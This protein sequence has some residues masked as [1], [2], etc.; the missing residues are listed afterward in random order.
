ME[1]SNQEKQL[2]SL[3]E[4][5]RAEKSKFNHRLL[6]NYVIKRFSDSV[7]LLDKR[8]GEMIKIKF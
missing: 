3:E 7:G 5:L 8:T 1:M 4:A 6:Q 2:T